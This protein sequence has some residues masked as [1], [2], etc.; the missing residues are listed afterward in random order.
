MKYQLVKTSN[1]IRSAKKYAR[2]NSD[3]LRALNESLTLLTK[4]PSTSKLKTHKLKGE[5]KEFWSCSVDYNIGILFQF[6]KA[7]D[8]V[9]GQP[10]EAILLVDIGSH[11]E[12]Y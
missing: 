2:N 7:I 5:L 6:V 12:V 1:F 8:S 4:D 10:V 9:S 11:D 3:F